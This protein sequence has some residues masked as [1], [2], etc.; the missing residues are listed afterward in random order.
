MF[1]NSIDDQNLNEILRL[2]ADGYGAWEELRL[3]QLEDYKKHN[4]GKESAT[5]SQAVHVAPP[6]VKA[7][8][9]RE[10][11]TIGKMR[12]WFPFAVA[13]FCPDHATYDPGLVAKYPKLTKLI[14]AWRQDNPTI[15]KW[16]EQNAAAV[17]AKI[18]RNPF[19]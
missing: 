6:P 3:Y 5:L 11:H 10:L 1:P 17:K 18:G 12:T 14:T 7:T 4:P 19:C 16:C 2:M 8:V 15:E 9:K 13:P